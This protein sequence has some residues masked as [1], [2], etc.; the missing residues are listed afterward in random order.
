MQQWSVGG[1]MPS[2]TSCGYILIFKSAPAD[3]ADSAGVMRGDNLQKHGKPQILGFSSAKK[4]I[5][6]WDS[7]E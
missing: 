3:S 4:H 2:L 7:I 1:V 5:G 6:H